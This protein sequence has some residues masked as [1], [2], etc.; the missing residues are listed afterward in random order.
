MNCRNGLLSTLAMGLLIA[1]PLVVT[2]DKDKIN[3][4]ATTIVTTGT[5][6]QAISITG[7]LPEKLAGAKATSEVRQYQPETLAELVADK[8]VI[9]QEYKIT[10]AASRLYGATRVEV[11]KTESPQA[12]FGLFTYTVRENP[13]QASWKEAAAA[14]TVISDGLVFWKHSYF[15]KV[16]N[17]TPGGKHSPAQAGVAKAVAELIPA[18]EE[19]LTHPLLLDSLPKISLVAHSERYFL[20]PESLNA[21]IAGARDRFSFDGKAEAVVAEYRKTGEAENHPNKGADKEATK[22]APSAK[23]KAST[24]AAAGRPVA[25]LSQPLQ[26]V[27]IEYHTP[28]LA[29]DAMNRLNGFEATLSE[30]ERTRFMTKRVGN[31]IIGA[32]NFQDREFAEALL[33]TVK[34]PYVVQWLQNPAIPTNDP[35][36]IQKAGQMLVSTFSLI[37]LSGGVML[38]CGAIMGTTI[39]LRRRKQQRELFSDAGGMIGLHLD[40]IEESMLSLPAAKREE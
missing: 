25:P 29:T 26:L 28:Q 39:F 3:D 12:A 13:N 8:A 14:G 16:S 38:L 4:N 32:T 24:A 19:P 33:N 35:F 5:R 18:G 31:F 40:P 27:I 6:P 7:L 11:C 1:A 9:Y 20:G 36:A 23:R 30:D 21:Y 2:A 22:Q 10:H 37:G 15:V 17:A 34:Y